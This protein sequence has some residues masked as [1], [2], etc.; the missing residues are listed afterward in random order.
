MRQRLSPRN[1]LIRCSIGAT[2]TGSLCGCGSG[3]RLLSYRL[4]RAGRRIRSSLRSYAMRPGNATFPQ[5]GRSRSIPLAVICDR[6]IEPPGGVAIRRRAGHSVTDQAGNR[7]AIQAEPNGPPF[8]ATNAPTTTILGG[9][10]AIYALPL[11]E[12]LRWQ[13]R[14]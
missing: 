14:T 9:H 11:A 7:R 12:F 10:C 8:F 13:A 2:G 1:G 5:N 4:R 3:A 6:P